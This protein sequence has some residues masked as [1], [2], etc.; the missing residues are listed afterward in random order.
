[1]ETTLSYLGLTLAHGVQIIN[2]E[3]RMSFVCPGNEKAGTRIN[4][5]VLE[6]LGL[7]HTIQS[8]YPLDM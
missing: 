6:T 3:A 4:A 8:E 7:S 5:Q 2:N 1:M